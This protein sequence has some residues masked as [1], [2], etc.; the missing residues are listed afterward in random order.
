ML[1]AAVSVFLATNPELGPSVRL[2]LGSKCQC[3][4]LELEPRALRN[5]NSNTELC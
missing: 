1:Q 3:E 5:L 4:E 2:C